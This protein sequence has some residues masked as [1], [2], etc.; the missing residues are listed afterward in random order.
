MIKEK[1]STP[2]SEIELTPG[3]QHA[4][5]LFKQFVESDKKVFILKGYAGT[6]KTTLVNTLV[7]ELRERNETFRLLAS[8]GRA[9]KVMRDKTGRVAST[10]HSAIYTF[11]DLN[12]D[13]DEL[14]KEEKEPPRMDNTGQLLLNFVFEEIKDPDYTRCF[15]IVDEASM[16]GDKEDK[17]PTQALFGSG[18]LLHDLLRY[19]PKGKYI[20]VGDNCQLP[21][22]GE[23]VSPALSK[24]YIQS[25]FNIECMDA[26]LNQ[27]V[28]QASGNDI[29]RAAQKIRNL[30]NDPPHN[31]FSVWYKFPLRGHQDVKIC[32]SQAEL[33][34]RYIDDIKAHGYEYATMICMSNR[35]SIKLSKLIRPSLGMLST[36]ICVNDLL[37]VT[38]NNLLSGLMNGDLV[39]VTQV[40]GSRQ[41]AG[42]TFQIVEMEEIVTKQRVSQ[43]IITDIVY[44]DGINLTQQ[45][46]KQL[47]LDYF[48]RMKEQGIKQKSAAFK[49]GMYKDPYLNALRATFGYVITCHKSQGGEWKKVYLDIPKILARETGRAEYQWLYTAIT[50][51]TDKLFIAEDFFLK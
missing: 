38:Q 23:A 15:Y 42:L 12:Q 22:V 1:T 7:K 40:K 31:P 21:P 45:Q 11:S 28:R 6:G 48:F 29:V 43:L 27:I 13:L 33:L 41:R 17:N 4:F 30:Y 19:D 49:D 3:Q 35:T 14:F 39:R 50:R 20:F 5:D 24:E 37:L 25:V 46:Q 26:E 51:A 10:I 32:T 47:Y 34:E 2:Q 9:A 44:S 8:T 16:I 36:T 18:K